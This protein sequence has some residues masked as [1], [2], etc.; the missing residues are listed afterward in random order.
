MLFQEEH[1]FFL[2][3]SARCG[4]AADLACF[5]DYSVAWCDQRDRV[6]AQGGADGTGGLG[7]VGEF[8]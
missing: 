8:G 2:L 5:G 7:V 3:Y 6:S 1:F 4:K